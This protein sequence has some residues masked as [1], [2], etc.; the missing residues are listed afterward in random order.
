MLAELLHEAV[1]LLLGDINLVVAFLLGV[2]LLIG[3]AHHLVGCNVLDGDAILLDNR[4]EVFDGTLNLGF[5]EGALQGVA[6]KF[7]ADGEVVAAF[8]PIEDGGACVPG[9]YGG[10]AHDV[11]C[12]VVVDDAVCAYLAWPFA[13]HFE[14]ALNGGLGCVVEDDALNIVHLVAVVVGGGV[15]YF[16]VVCML[17][18]LCRHGTAAHRKEKDAEEKKLYFHHGWEGILSPSTRGLGLWIIM[19]SEMD[20]GEPR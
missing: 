9:D 6:L 15:G 8:A 1:V 17:G 4:Q 2:F 5:G 20:G 13:E 3:C 19:E 16:L 18:V 10:G 11:A 14:G 7:D 12:A